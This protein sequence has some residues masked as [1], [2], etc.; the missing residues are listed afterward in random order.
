MPV[1]M[2]AQYGSLHIPDG[3]I[4]PS[5]NPPVVPQ[6][7]VSPRT[8]PEY[9]RR[10]A[11]TPHHHPQSHYRGP[12]QS[13]PPVLPVNPAVMPPRPF[14]EPTSSTMTLSLSPPFK[15]FPPLPEINRTKPPTPPPKLLDLAPYRDT[16]SHFAH[17]SPDS[18]NK[19]LEIIQDRGKTDVRRAHEEWRRQDEEREKVVREKKEARDRLISGANTIMAPTMQTLTTLVVDPTTR[20]PQ[21]PP[22]REKKRSLW[23]RLFKPGKSGR[24]RRQSSMLSNGPLVVPIDPRQVLPSIPG[25]VIP[26]DVP[27]DVPVDVRVDAPTQSQSSTSQTQSQTPRQTPRHGFRQMPTPAATL[28]NPSTPAPKY[29][30]PVIPGAVGPPVVM[31]SPFLYRIQRSTTPELSPPPTAAFYSIPSPIHV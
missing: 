26:M 23:S 12:S 16:F 10:P 6:D 19:A 29:G 7:V 11:A 20:E 1:P 9:W 8:D 5:V 3:Y 21:P 27:M 14:S 18:R 13:H 22:P 17:P 28:V 25:V 15:P 24:N 4:P 30:G 2:T 31:P